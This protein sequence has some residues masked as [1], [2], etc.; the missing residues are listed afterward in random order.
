M[1]T[2]LFDISDGWKWLIQCSKLLHDKIELFQ[3]FFQQL[4]SNDTDITAMSY[5]CSYAHLL[6]EFLT[7][8]SD[9]LFIKYKQNLINVY[10]RLY[11][12]INSNLYDFNVNEQIISK[13]LSLF[14]N[15]SDIEI[16]DYISFYSFKVY[17]LVIFLGSYI[18]NHSNSNPDN[19]TDSKFNVN[20]NKT[21]S[22]KDTDIYC[23]L[24]NLKKVEI[25]SLSTN[26][27]LSSYQ[28]LLFNC[29]KD[30]KRKNDSRLNDGDKKILN[31]RIEY[32]GIN[33]EVFNA[34]ISYKMDKI[35]SIGSNIEVYK[36]VESSSDDV[37]NSQ[38]NIIDK[39][40]YYGIN[41][42]QGMFN[43]LNIKAE[44]HISFT[45]EILESLNRIKTEE[46]KVIYSI[47]FVYT[48]LYLFIL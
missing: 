20:S 11:D 40:K 41:R 9:A 13:R 28:K 6:L 34:I 44:S 43:R 27:V 21:Q 29:G 4:S 1:F 24:Y 8:T 23:N 35:I 39:I 46:G 2:G 36:P 22:S 47:E 5:I 38:Y 18:S 33:F 16:N 45:N 37:N 10:Q 12:M 30:F 7:I 25:N 42:L 48:I 32:C 19:K 14:G 15:Y 3:I 31:V 26:G 17:D